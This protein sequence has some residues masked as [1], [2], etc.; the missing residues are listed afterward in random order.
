MTRR[1]GL[2]VRVLVGA[3]LVAS[4]AAEPE[5]V[6]EEVTC[7]EVI[8]D[9]TEHTVLVEDTQLDP[10][11]PSLRPFVGGCYRIVCSDDVS[12]PPPPEDEEG[13]RAWE[14]ERARQARAEDGCRIV[15]GVIVRRAVGEGVRP[16]DVGAWN[17][18]LAAKRLPEALGDRLALPARLDDPRLD[19]EHGTRVASLIAHGAR[20]GLRIVLLQGAIRSRAARVA[21]PTSEAVARATQLASDPEVI[22]AYA[23]AEPK[24]VDEDRWALLR[25]HRVTLVNESFGSSRSDLETACPGRPWRAYLAAEEA[26]ELAVT[27]TRDARGVFGGLAVTTVRAAG[28]EAQDVS[29]PGDAR[30]SCRGRGDAPASLGARSALVVIGSYDP[31]TKEASRFTN[32]GACVDAY[33]AGER[34]LTRGFDDVLYPVDGTS[35][36]APLVTRWLAQVTRSTMS[37]ADV[38]RFVRGD[39]G[40][41]ERS[42]RRLPDEASPPEL[43]FDAKEVP[44]AP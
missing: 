25:R 30:M 18:A 34:V 24:R 17:R 35:V 3:V 19:S 27:R 20:P 42:T 10:R 33:A 22:R 8:G 31:S 7:P 40:D 36:A 38:R 29:A 28:N 12:R 11:V 44:L 9:G 14:I 21:C 43:L 32:Y 26:L 23:E 1:R 15:P 13:R 6:V 37:P 39:L 5:V 2:A 4:C 41:T 16:G